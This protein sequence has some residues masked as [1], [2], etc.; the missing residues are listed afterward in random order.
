MAKG[1]SSCGFFN[2]SLSKAWVTTGCTNFRIVR[3]PANFGCCGG[4]RV[5]RG[6]IKV[7]RD[8][9]E[10]LS[11]NSKFRKKDLRGT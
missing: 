3:P 9:L 2:E 10:R 7:A 1:V 4:R 8:S 6:Q 5:R 11:A